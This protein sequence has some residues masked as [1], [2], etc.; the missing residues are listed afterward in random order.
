M[1]KGIAAA[2][3]ESL[4]GHGVPGAAVALARAG[5]PFYSHG[6]GLANLETATPVG[7]ATVFRYGSLT[8]QF[9]AAAA[10][11]LAAQGKLD[12]GAPVLGLLPAFKQLKP[13]STLELMHQT[14]GLHSD[15]SEELPS[16]AVKARNQIEL[17]AEIAGQAKPFDFDPGTA[18]LYSNA[19]F[20][21][22]GAVIEQVTKL[23]LAQAMKALVFDPLGLTSMAI[24]TPDEIVAGR[25]SGYSQTDDPAR[26][27]ANAA[28]A[29]PS[30]AGGAGAMRG[31]VMDLVRWHAA[32]LSGK[33]FDQTH[34]SLMTAPGKLRDGRLSGANRYSSDDA[35]YG[36]TQYACGLLVTGPSEVNPSILHY[37]SFYGFCAMVQTF[38]RKNV[39]IA[40]LCNSDLG[41]GVPFR[42]IRK[43]VIAGW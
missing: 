37:G 36:D 17:A 16:Q 27:F 6:F 11:R 1:A 18:W 3:D 39:T 32:L 21:V 31:T 9:V 43:A 14:A 5:V 23:P 25:A 38:T 22:L 24:D 28:Y 35:H 10:I 4:R 2:V 12:L 29:D 34:V 30:Q 42:G 13:F 15:E 8:K 26:P 41:P 40:A 7:I 19:N 20:I 33:L